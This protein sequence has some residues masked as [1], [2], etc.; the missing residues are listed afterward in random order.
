[1]AAIVGAVPVV[2][3]FFL[4]LFLFSLLHPLW[5]EE[6]EGDQGG[7]VLVESTGGAK[8]ADKKADMGWLV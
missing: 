7:D 3:C 2:L 6:D 8:E 4:A 5:Q 1:M